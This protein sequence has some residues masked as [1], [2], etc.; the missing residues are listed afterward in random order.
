MVPKYITLLHV[1]NQE[2]LKKLVALALK[3]EGD[4]VEVGV[5]QGGTARLIK[6]T[7]GKSDKILHLFDTFT[8]MPKSEYLGSCD[9]HHAPGEFRLTSLSLVKQVVGEDNVLYYPGIFPETAKGIEDKKFCFVHVDCDLYQSYKD[10]LEFFPSRIISGFIL[11]DDY[12]HERCLGA[13]KAIDEF[14]LVNKDIHFLPHEP[15][16][17][18]M[19]FGEA[20][21]I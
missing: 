21:N 18:T 1:E 2:K 10:C 3:W 5:F 7:M 4:L 20:Q 15:Y 17:A 16:G 8:G 13:T 19:M 9:R 11:F 6:S 14:L 12:K